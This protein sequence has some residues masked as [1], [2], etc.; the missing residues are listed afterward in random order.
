LTALTGELAGRLSD[1]L[2]AYGLIP[3]GG[4]AFQPG[5]EA[6]PGLSGAPAKVVVLVGHGGAPHWRHFR[7]WR[8]DRPA[9]LAN[10][11][12]KWSAEVIDPVAAEAG[13]RAVYPSQRPYL[14]FQQWAMRAERLRPSPLG[15]L[16]HPVFGLWHAY[17][18]A[19]LF[20][21]AIGWEQLR[22]LIQRVAEPS[23]LCDLCL[24]K[25]CLK[26]CPV[27][28]YK[29]DGFDYSGCRAH[30]RGGEGATCR[31]EGCLDRN[32]CPEGAIY[33]YPADMQAFHMAAFTAME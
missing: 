16:M 33:R 3:R 6:P 23:H 15:V 32:A 22:V 14:P 24:G 17:R 27:E 11:L 8:A 21:Q 5:E 25:P 20:D 1:A 13:A 31:Q 19:L 30:V 26:S 28:A 7:D 18:G 4:F 2:A 10:P 12:D 9:D 29:A